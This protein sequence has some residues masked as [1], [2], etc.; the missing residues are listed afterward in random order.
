MTLETFQN[1]TGTS[2]YEQDFCEWIE[3]TVRQLQEKQ[4]SQVDWENLIEE[5]DSMGRSER[6]ALA[7][8]LQIV[9]MHL[10]KYKYQPEKRSNSWKFTLFEHRDRLLEAIEASPSLN[11]Y[12]REVFDKCYAKARKKASLEMGLPTGAFPIESPFTPEETLDTEY[13]PEYHD[14][15]HSTPRNES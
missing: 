14:S 6:S 9:L 15:K 12:F 2:L 4:F 11:P 10:L 5:L 13:L 1:R 7:S 3:T 8:N